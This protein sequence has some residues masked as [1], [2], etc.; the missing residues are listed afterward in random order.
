MCLLSASEIFIMHNYKAERKRKMKKR[1]LL[2]VFAVATL[3]FASIIA[4]SA[5]QSQSESE[6]TFTPGSRNHLYTVSESYKYSKVWY[7]NSENK[8]TAGHTN[9]IAK[10]SNTSSALKQARSE[11]CT[12]ACKDNTVTIVLNGDATVETKFDNEGQIMGTVV[13]DL[14]G[15]TVDATAVEMINAQ[16]KI[17][18]SSVYDSRIIYKT[19]IL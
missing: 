16:A 1:I 13:I 9:L 15:Y 3:L 6:P 2:L 12:V 19:E 11:L 10:N 8:N 14:N 17:S 5:A 18:N 7:F 4:V